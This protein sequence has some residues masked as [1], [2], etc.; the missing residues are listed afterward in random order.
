[1]MAVDD[2]TIVITANQ[3]TDDTTDYQPSSGVEVMFLGVADGVVGGTAPNKAPD[4]MLSLINGTDNDALYFQN[5]QDA[6]N[7][8]TMMYNG[9]YMANNTNYFRFQTQHS[10]TR[11]YGF[12]VIEVG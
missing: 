6:G 7:C 11:D 1:M 4:I 5:G 12:A 8:A 2:V 10:G 9:K 3:P